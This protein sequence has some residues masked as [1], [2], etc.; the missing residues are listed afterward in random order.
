M[1]PAG[2]ANAVMTAASITNPWSP[3]PAEV[4]AIEAAASRGDSAEGALLA[5]FAK[6]EVLEA[7]AHREPL[8]GSLASL[9]SAMP[10]GDGDGLRL[11]S[12]ALVSA[13]E[14][15]FDEVPGE[16]RDRRGPRARPEAPPRNTSRRML[17]SPA[18]LSG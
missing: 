7:D 6:Y 13:A 14:C 1:D 11:Y 17:W 5:Q 16:L 9:A 4:H 3:P 18:S 10:G 15:T 2:V 12:N 8:A